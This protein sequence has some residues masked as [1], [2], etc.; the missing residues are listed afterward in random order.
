MEPIFLSAESSH[1]LLTYQEKGQ[2][3][4]LQK[5]KKPWIVLRLNPQLCLEKEGCLTS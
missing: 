4:V 2:G 5:V 3:R 1:F